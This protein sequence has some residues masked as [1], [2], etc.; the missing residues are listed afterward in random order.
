MN[1]EARAGV[2]GLAGV[3]EDAPADRRRRGFEIAD[4]GKNDLR[5]LAAQ[6]ERDRLH[7]GFANRAEQR[8]PH[9]GRAGERDLVN[10][11]VASQRRTDHVAPPGDHVEDA[12]G[13]SRLGREL[14]A[15]LQELPLIGRHECQRP[16][17]NEIRHYLVSPRLRAAEEDPRRRINRFRVR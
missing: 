3:V 10:T 17:R 16:V 1:D 4:V 8:L 2:A 14:R 13:Q 6:L 5:A 7:V 12:I 11:G 15:S 9:L